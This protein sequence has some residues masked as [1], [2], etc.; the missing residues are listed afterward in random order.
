M[1][2]VSEFSETS[3]YELDVGSNASHCLA[4][5]SFGALEEILP[6]DVRTAAEHGS[7]DKLALAREIDVKP[8]A[9]RYQSKIVS[10]RP[11]L[12]W[13]AGPTAYRAPHPPNMNGSTCSPV[14]RQ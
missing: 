13:R 8:I 2:L 1:E 9:G 12:P 6:S 11:S 14:I 4:R 10:H 7:P 3:D 5:D